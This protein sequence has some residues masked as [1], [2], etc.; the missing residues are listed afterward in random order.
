MRF[1]L[2]LSLTLGFVSQAQPQAP[3]TCWRSILA[4]TPGLSADYDCAKSSAS[5]QLSELCLED[6]VAYQPKFEAYLIQRKKFEQAFIAYAKW[7]KEKPE[8]ELPDKIQSDLAKEITL[9]DL[10]F[11]RQSIES[12]LAEIVQLT[13]SCR[14]P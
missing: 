11:D 5:S 2:F 8:G 4:I 9:W 3:P 13:S 1:S 12:Q 10:V 14:L 6:G 7:K